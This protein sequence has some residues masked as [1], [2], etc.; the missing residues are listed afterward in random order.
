MF[1][2][3]S[4]NDRRNRIEKSN[5]QPPTAGFPAGC[6]RAVRAQDRSGMVCATGATIRIAAAPLRE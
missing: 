1:A 5:E 2:R 3:R 4:L 6:D